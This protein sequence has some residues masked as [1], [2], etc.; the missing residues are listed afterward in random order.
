VLGVESKWTQR[1]KGVSSKYPGCIIAPI[2]ELEE[3]SD[4]IY[5]D[6]GFPPARTHALCHISLGV[7][8]FVRRFQHRTL[9][10]FGEFGES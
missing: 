5:S 4:Y 8:C 10:E 3:V 2:S 1:E 9:V 6:V 7:L